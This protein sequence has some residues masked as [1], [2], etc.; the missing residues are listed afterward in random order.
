MNTQTK[1]TQQDRIRIMRF[2]THMLT[3][4]WQQ[5]EQELDQDGESIRVSDAASIADIFS[6]LHDRPF[7][8]RDVEQEISYLDTE[9]RDWVYE[10]FLRTMPQSISAKVFDQTWTGYLREVRQLSRMQE[11]V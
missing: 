2:F 9:Y 5:A 1:L 10:E 4:T 7:T 3:I 6:R 11:M 8:R